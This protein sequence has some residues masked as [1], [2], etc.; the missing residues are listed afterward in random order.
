[1]TQPES[2]ARG[3]AGVLAGSRSRSLPRLIGHVLGAFVLVEAVL[4][5]LGLLV[6]R[7]LAHSA[8]HQDELTFERD[9]VAH[10]TTF[11]DQITR[12][13][14][15]LGATETVIALTA[16][17]CLLLAWRGH[18]PRLPVFLALAVAGETGLFLIASVVVHR[19]RPAIP[20][21]DGAP[22]TSSF[23][24]GH[25]AATLALALGLALGLARTR[26]THPLR[27]MS[28]FL[29]VALPL[30]VLASRLYRGMHW[31]TDVAASI[32]FTITWLLLLRAI[33]LPP[34]VSDRSPRH[35]TR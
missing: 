22:P 35:V 25:T 29:A 24:S 5:G 21:L 10:R 4:L 32:V 19:M 16:V 27:A 23:P 9:V 14:T 12:Y 20:H 1:M 28:W 26:P 7:V 11:W 17:G 8:L 34:D 13:G 6:T 33:L 18:G 31:P 2:G 30:F 15:L 3:R